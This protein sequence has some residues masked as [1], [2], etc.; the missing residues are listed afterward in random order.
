MVEKTI[1][2]VQESKEMTAQDKTRSDNFYYYP[3]VDIF[4]HNNELVVIADVPGVDKENTNIKVEDNILTVDAKTCDA[5]EGES[6]CRE[7]AWGNFHRQFELSDKI[8][9]NKISAE[10]KNGVLTIHLPI[11]E[12]A[13]KL[14]NV[15]TV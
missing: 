4:E 12:K 8:D 10:L 13:T 2:S 6:I 14:I 7:F 5:S 9:E 3:P 15:K 11:V 1:P